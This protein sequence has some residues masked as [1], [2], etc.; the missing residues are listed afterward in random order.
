MISLA[1]GGAIGAVSR[2]LLTEWG[3]QHA[4]YPSI[5]SFINI[6]GSFLFGFIVV[7]SSSWT[8]FLC[9]GVL[10]GFTTF[11]TFIIDFWTLLDQH[12]QTQAF[13]YFSIS[14]FCSIAACFLGLLL[15][16]IT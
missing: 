15:G 1:F 11:S 7:Q 5:T 6:V 2:Y 14:I 16:G 10:G 12:K 4:H 9:A 8:A 13:I 3:K